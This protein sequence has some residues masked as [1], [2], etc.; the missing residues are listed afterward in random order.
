[1]KKVKFWASF[2]KMAHSRVY[3]HGIMENVDD[4]VRDALVS[5]KNS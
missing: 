1:M 3:S 4:E 5:L 2:E